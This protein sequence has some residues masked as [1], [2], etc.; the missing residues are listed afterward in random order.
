[1]KKNFIILFFGTLLLFSCK[2]KIVKPEPLVAYLEDSSI[3]VIDDELL[4]ILNPENGLEILSEGHDW[5]EGPLWIEA[6]K[7]LLF[8]DIPRNT[9]YSWNENTG[10]QVYLKPSGFTG[11]D[12]KGSEPG[13]NGLLLD[14]NGNLILC[15]HGN[16]QVARMVNPTTDPKPE[17]VALVE[18][19]D[20]KRLNSPNDGVFDSKGNLYFTDPPYGLPKRMED[21]SKELKFQGVYRYDAE[22]DLHIM[23]AELSRPNGIAFSPDEKTLYV[24]NSDPDHAIWMAYDLD[25]EGG[26]LSKRVFYD[27]TVLTSKEKGLPDGLKVNDAG[28]LFATGPGGVLIFNPEG[29][30][31][32]TIRTNR[33]TSNVALNTDQTELFITADSYVLKLKLK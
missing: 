17:Y 24:A 1:M 32:G 28:F 5:T 26:I 8:S 29:K 12:F 27:A 18:A 2:E 25:E 3:E 21:P 7:T 15:Q 31:L 14:P 4:T 6:Q 30:R 11:E 19:F 23:D 22:G 33:A 10:V 20:G 16:R 13:A 9:V